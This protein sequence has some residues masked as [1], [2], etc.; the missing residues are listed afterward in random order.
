MA[1]AA[2]RLNQEDLAFQGRKITTRQEAAVAAH[3]VS[4]LMEPTLTIPKEEWHLRY[5]AINRAAGV[6][7]GHCVAATDPF[8]AGGRK[9]CIVAAQCL[10]A[11]V[12]RLFA[13]DSAAPDYAARIK[14]CGSLAKRVAAVLVEMGL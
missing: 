4:G 3:I 2:E 7:A 6:I 1:T 10:Q 12:E 14:L 11:S 5:R 8:T 13:G 9:E